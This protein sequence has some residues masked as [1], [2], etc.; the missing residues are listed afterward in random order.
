MPDWLICGR[1]PYCLDEEQIAWV[2]NTLA[3]P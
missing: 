3:H 1:K 2:E